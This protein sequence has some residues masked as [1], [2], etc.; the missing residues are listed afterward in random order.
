MTRLVADGNARAIS[1]GELAALFQPLDAI[2]RHP[3]RA[4][5]CLAVSGGADSMALMLLA[6]RWRALDPGRA[7]V[8]D[9]V[10]VDHRL[11]LASAGEARLVAETAAR[12]GFGHHTLAWTAPK[13][14]TGLMAAAR[15]ARLGLMIE[16]ATQTGAAAIVLAQTAE[17]QAETLLMRLARG[18]GVDGLASMAPVSHR[19]G[20]AIVRPLLAI[21][22]ARLVAT[23]VEAGVTWIDDPS[24][25]DDRFERVRV[26]QEAAS[27]HRLGL[28]AK[29]LALTAHRLGRASAALRQRT[30]ELLAMPAIVTF[31]AQGGARVYC[32]VL[33]LQPADL[34]VRVLQAVVE[35]IGGV[36]DPSLLAKVETL[37]ATAPV[38]LS[39]RRTLGR[40]MLSPRG[41]RLANM[42]A[43][44]IDVVREQAR[45]ALPVIELRPGETAIWDHR[46]RVSLAPDAASPVT[47]QAFGHGLRSSHR[48]DVTATVP[49]FFVGAE[50]LAAPAIGL[51]QSSLCASVWIGLELTQPGRGGVP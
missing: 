49:G 32:D 5:L 43:N 18:S 31:S 14:A 9:V 39:R 48:G 30:A 1:D 20:V 6:A 12:L 35:A 28:D 4:R 3:D 15:E 29:A 36:C 17:D 7:I 24:N 44:A 26:R 27:L 50:L 33:A 16:H 45:A 42:S 19:D 10:T 11:R 40:V 8:I 47:V 46:F 2:C 51:G 21:G 25:E 38:S 41:P 37:V 22:R 34:Q 23:L 13:P